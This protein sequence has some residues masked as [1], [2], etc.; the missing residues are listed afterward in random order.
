MAG[1][2]SDQASKK[3]WQFRTEIFSSVAREQK[4][5]HKRCAFAERQ[6]T[7]PKIL[8]RKV[9]SAVRREMMAQ[10]KLYEAET[11]DEARNRNSDIACHGSIKRLNLNDFNYNKQVDGQIRLKEIKSVC[12]KNWNWEIGS[13]KK[14][15][16]KNVKKLINWEEFVAKKLIEHDKRDQT[17][18]L[19]I[20]RG[21]LRMLTQIQDLQNNVNSLS[22]ARELYDPES[23]SNS[24]A[25]HVPDR[26]STVLSASYTE[27][28][29]YC[30]TRFWTTTCSTRTILYD[31]QQFKEFGNHPLRDWDLILP[32]QQGERVEWKENRWIRRF[33]HIISKV[34][35]ECW[36]ILVKLILT[37]EW[38]IFR[39]FLF[40]NGIL[41]S[42]WFYGISTLENKLQNWCLSTNSRSSDH[43]A[44]DKRSWN[45]QINGRTCDISIDY[46]EFPCN[47]CLSSST[48]TPNSVRYKFT[49]WR[50]SKF[51]LQM[52]SC[53]IICQWNAV[54]SDPGRI[55]QIKNYRILLHFRLSW[56]RREPRS[57]TVT[58]WKLL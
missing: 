35:V 45:C 17:N 25:T 53:C 23:R 56:L 47:W 3:L 29:G 34:E 43:D 36:I 40:R 18:C 8:E 37:M 33:N 20:K 22:D 7:S 52:G 49:E 19:C 44:L 26:T 11:E 41:E 38:W 15:M 13:S 27:W 21:I 39:S 28:Y 42:F 9:D 46:K 30:R 4:S 31:L 32:I 57:R 50:C 14:I 2:V 12:M 5:R 58:N 16:Q 55:V 1:H 48:R 10:R 51:R 24:R 6:R 54:R